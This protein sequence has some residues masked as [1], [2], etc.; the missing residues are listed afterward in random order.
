MSIV[1]GAYRTRILARRAGAD[2]T[3]LVTRN[4]EVSFSA[5]EVS[6]DVSFSNAYFHYIGAQRGNAET[7][8]C[9]TRV[10]LDGNLWKTPDGVFRILDTQGNPRLCAL[11]VHRGEFTK[12][13]TECRPSG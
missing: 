11:E 5:E 1:N 2:S 13:I 8:G 12:H 6:I 4:T 7:P 3:A 9:K 10:P